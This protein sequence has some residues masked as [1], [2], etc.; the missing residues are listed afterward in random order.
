MKTSYYLLLTMVVC[1]SGCAAFQ[2]AS[3]VQSGR[4]AL[5]RGNNEVALAHFQSAAQKNPNYVYGTALRQSIWNYV[6]RAE[7]ATAR[8]PQAR[9]SFE[10]ALELDREDNLARL[11]L[12][13]TLARQGD[14]QKGLSEIESGM[15][16]INNWLE[17][18]TQAH[19]YSF[20]QYWDPTR[21]IRTVIQTDLAMISGRDVDWQRLIADGEW[22]GQRMEE[23]AEHARRQESRDLSREGEGQNG[24]P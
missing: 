15:K 19:R 17:Y 18:V 23:E 6:G 7:Y 16:G 11:Y 9:E 10:R 13:L 2:T 8:Y 14:Q 12:G 20:G 24:R 21:E 22:L 5:F 4:Q 1:L 3:E